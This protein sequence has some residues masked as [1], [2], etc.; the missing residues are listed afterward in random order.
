MLYEVASGLRSRSNTTYLNIS[1]LPVAPKIADTGASEN[2]SN[3][4]QNCDLTATNSRY[5]GGLVGHH[6]CF[7]VAG[8]LLLVS[9]PLL[10]FFVNL[11]RQKIARHMVMV[12]VAGA[13]WGES[14]QRRPSMVAW[15]VYFGDFI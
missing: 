12:V 8:C 1:G 3:W 11:G 13:A 10:V 4:T 15:G 7:L 2:V 5:W 14:T 9:E 6:I